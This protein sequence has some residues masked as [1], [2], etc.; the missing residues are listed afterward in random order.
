MPPIGLKPF[1]GM[2][3][4]QHR[5][6]PD[7]PEDTG[8]HGLPGAG[9]SGGGESGETVATDHNVLSGKRE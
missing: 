7:F 3:W 8:L 2:R 9:T 1:P 5:S 6:F 4:D